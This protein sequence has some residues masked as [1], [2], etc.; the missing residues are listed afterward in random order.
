VFMM[1]AGKEAINEIDK[2][3]VELNK[4]QASLSLFYYDKI[5]R[6]L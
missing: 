5:G 1:E 3:I 4:E 6:M 2:M